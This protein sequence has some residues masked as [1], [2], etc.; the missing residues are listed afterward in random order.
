MNKP[1]RI[2]VTGP[3]STAKSTLSQ[4]LAV[5]FGA[6]FFPEYARLYLDRE[7]TDYDYSDVVKI[8]E[9]QVQQYKDSLEQSY[10]F[11]FFDTWLINTKVWFEWV[12][13]Q[14][15]DWLENKIED[16][17]IDLYLLCKPDIEWQP[18]PLRE[19]GGEDR[20]RLFNI[21][22]E[23]LL[24]RNFNFAEIGGEGK[25]RLE[26]AIKAVLKFQETTGI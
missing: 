3:E 9:G 24:Q 25:L 22:K 21:Y 10:K 12:Y 17:P 20:I 19:N 5:Q 8:A 13:Q 26:N 4:Q 6:K 11:Y 18:D 23:E 1:Y 16:C 7:G 15:P 2:V 14:Y